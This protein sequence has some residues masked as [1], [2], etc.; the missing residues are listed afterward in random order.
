MATL[1]A[2]EVRLILPTEE[3]KAAAVTA[4]LD[5]LKTP[6]AQAVIEALVDRRIREMRP[7]ARK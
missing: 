1:D 2:V 7:R 3:E 4:L 6:E 5:L